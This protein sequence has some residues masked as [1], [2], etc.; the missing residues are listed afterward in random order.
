MSILI[1][2]T[3]LK[4]INIDIY[5]YKLYTLTQVWVPVAD[6][7]ICTKCTI[8]LY[9]KLMSIIADLPLEYNQV[10]MSYFFDVFILARQYAWHIHIYSKIF[11]SGVMHGDTHRNC[12]I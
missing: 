7:G 10:Q 6:I 5:L 2:Y 1:K 11:M 12:S 3:I 8:F 9:R 4:P